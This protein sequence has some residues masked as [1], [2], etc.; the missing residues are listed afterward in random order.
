MLSRIIVSVATL[1]SSVLLSACLFGSDKNSCETISDCLNG[2]ECVDQKCVPIDDGTPTLACVDPAGNEEPAFRDGPDLQI[3]VTA[4]RGDSDTYVEYVVRN[5]GNE[6]SGPF[7]V[8]MFINPPSPPRAGDAPLAAEEQSSLAPGQS[9]SGIVVTMNGTELPPRGK[10]YVYA[11][12][13]DE[14]AESREDN[15]L[16]RPVSFHIEYVGDYLD[17]AHAYY[18]DT[19]AN[20]GATG[21]ATEI[22]VLAANGTVIASS[23]RETGCF[24][25]FAV[26]LKD[27]ADPSHVPYRVDLRG[28]TGF[29]PGAYSVQITT[30]GAFEPSVGA[31]ADPDAYEPDND[32]SSPPTIVVNGP[33]QDHSIGPTDIDCM[34]FSHTN[35]SL[36]PCATGLVRC[37]TACVNPLH[38]RDFCGATTC[39]D[40]ATDGEVCEA[41]YKCGLGTCEPDCPEGEIVCGGA[42]IDPLTSRDY[43][44]ATTCEDDTTDGELCVLGLQCD[45]GTCAP[46]N[47]DTNAQ[48]LVET[49]I[50]YGTCG[51]G[52][53]CYADAVEPVAIC[54]DLTSGAATQTQNESCVIDS[55]TACRRNGCASGFASLLP[56]KPEQPDGFECA[57]W[58]SPAE[59]YSQSPDLANGING[60]CQLPRLFDVGGT[61]GNVSEHQCRFVQTFDTASGVASDIGMC[62]PINSAAGGSWGDCRALDWDGLR[63]AWN[64]A[65]GAGT[66]AQEAFNIFCYGSPAPLD[67]DLVLPRCLGFFHGCLS[68]AEITG[69]GIPVP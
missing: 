3:H 10:A 42:C 31:P 44:G 49:D 66:S 20:G 58:C 26:S 47:C 60:N 65:L 39:Q 22:R 45:A 1:C 11:D 18:I 61:N 53:G 51:A 41:L 19:Y 34:S 17:T 4:V 50:T 15:N 12:L 54:E 38:D 43:C 59:A 6:A 64:T 30:N 13:L 52:Q 36:E 7:T 32:C 33:T 8:S 55:G 23:A 69:A 68:E 5:D 35:I 16:S 25:R 28:A 67:T 48:T 40:E 29:N 57:R 63:A 46:D 2:R 56:N 62:V 24:D 14:V 37:G 9:V 21:G 27:S